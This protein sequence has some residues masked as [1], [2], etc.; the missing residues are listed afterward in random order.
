MTSDLILEQVVRALESDAENAGLY[1]GL[2]PGHSVDHN[3]VFGGSRF[4]GGS[5]DYDTQQY[6]A[7]MQKFRKL[8][9]GS[10]QLGSEYA[11]T[12]GVSS[13][14]DANPS[15][16]EMQS[17]FNSG[18]AAIDVREQAPVAVRVGNGQVPPR[19]TGGPMQWNASQSPVHLRQR[20][21][22]S[23]VASSVRTVG[24][25]SDLPTR[26]PPDPLGYS[27]SNYSG[28]YAPIDYGSTP[29]TKLMEA[30][31]EEGR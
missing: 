15:S 6:N 9:L 25:R 26:P 21:A 16:T 22:G 31:I 24:T 28:E 7:D 29:R 4:G 19:S 12:S 18:E 20:S 11:S 2:K 30:R 14:Y 27:S 17:D 23:S 5:S 13:E 8:A 10:Q 3:A 1:Q